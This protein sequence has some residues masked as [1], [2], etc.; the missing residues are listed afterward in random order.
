ML[1]RKTP[2]VL[3]VTRVDDSLVWN[4][5][6]MMIYMTHMTPT[7]INRPGVMTIGLIVYKI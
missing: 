5:M 3:A 1:L 4:Y 6:Y 7:S 2:E